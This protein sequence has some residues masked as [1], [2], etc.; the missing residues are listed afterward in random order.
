MPVPKDVPAAV[1]TMLEAAGLNVSEE[2]FKA[3]VEMYPML[4]EATDTL[5]IEEVRY[6]EPA[7]VFTP[8]APMKG[9]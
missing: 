3:F 7:L 4:R 1:R 8:V 2:E 9:A 6:E 5:Y